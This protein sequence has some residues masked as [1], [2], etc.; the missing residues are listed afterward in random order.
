MTG[1]ARDE[2]KARQLGMSYGML[3]A[4]SVSMSVAAAP[5][6]E[7]QKATAQEAL[8]H[9]PN[10]GRLVEGHRRIYCDAECG[11]QFRSRKHYREKVLRYRQDK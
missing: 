3:K 10:C 9:C 5:Q 2:A 6:G 4:L 1:I 8:R 7:G 11:S